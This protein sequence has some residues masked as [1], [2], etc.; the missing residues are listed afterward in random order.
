[1]AES[2]REA[3]ERGQPLRCAEYRR[4]DGGERQRRVEKII[5]RCEGI[6]ADVV[7]ILDETVEVFKIPPESG[8]ERK[9]HKKINGA[10]KHHAAARSPEGQCVDDNDIAE[11]QGAERER[12]P[13]LEPGE[14]RPGYD[15]GDCQQAGR[16]PSPPRE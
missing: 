12:L 3:W 2:T 8:A 9:Q 15:P 13:R 6:N 14:A 4:Q 5:A 10:L 7:P 16:Q 1:M 11:P